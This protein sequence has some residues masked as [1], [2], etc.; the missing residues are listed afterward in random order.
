MGIDKMTK[1]EQTA[2]TTNL[3]STFTGSAWFGAV[4]AWP[5]MEAFGRKRPMQVSAFL[6]NLGA[7]LMTATTHNLGMIYAGRAITGFAVGEWQI[8]RAS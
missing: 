8:H 4:F 3:T 7:V 5:C 6:F 1:A 2:M